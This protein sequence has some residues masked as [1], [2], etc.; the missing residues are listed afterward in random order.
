MDEGVARREV[1][2][3]GLETGARE[4]G[5]GVRARPETI[6]FIGEEMERRAEQGRELQE[7]ANG[8]KKRRKARKGSG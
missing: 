7:Q 3:D 1:G 4:N 5:P 2:G 6:H 8:S